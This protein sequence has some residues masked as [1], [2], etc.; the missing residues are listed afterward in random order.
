[1]N[2][3]FFG[4]SS[5]SIPVLE[6]LLDSKHKVLHV[7]TTPDRKKGR[8]QKMAATQ[9]KQF[10]LEKGLPCS[11]PEK[12]RDEAFVGPIK[13]LVLDLLVVASYGKMVPNSMLAIPKIA[14]LNIHPSLLPKYRGASPIQSAILNGD[15][16]TGVSIAEVTAELDAG[17]LF[18]Q[19]TTEIGENEN[20]EEL[21][22]R[23][24]RLGGDIL[25]EVIERFEKGKISR[26][27]QNPAFAS[28]THKLHKDF[29]AIDWSQTASQIH[30]LVRASYPW[31]AG[32]TFLH[33]K[34]LKILS[35][36]LNPK[37]Q[38]NAAPGTIFEISK[39]G[40]IEVTARNGSILLK[41]VQQEGRSEMNASEFARGEHIEKGECF[42]SS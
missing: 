41:R 11:S 8:G 13:K 35:T 38:P 26:T 21:S 17:D 14:S 18:G 29:G 6:A 27:P 1:M 19:I 20:A 36:L 16:E 25:L 42:E 28:V 39:D 30:N 23:L 3:V 40:T 5:F 4:S 32:F 31:P 34:R 10:A 33:G 7:I 15:T 12:L 37:K 2:I 22:G 24:A 9:V